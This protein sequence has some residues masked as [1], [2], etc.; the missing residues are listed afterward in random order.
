[1]RD[2]AP[3]ILLPASDKVLVKDA[4]IL[5]NL[6]TTNSPTWNQF[7]HIRCKEGAIDSISEQCRNLLDAEKGFYQLLYYFRFNSDDIRCKS[8]RPMLCATLAHTGY[9]RISSFSWQDT[10]GTIGSD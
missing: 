2:Q 5:K 4:D 10:I 1:M 6:P 9:N 3:P 8:L 7:I